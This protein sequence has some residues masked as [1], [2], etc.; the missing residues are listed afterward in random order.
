[1]PTP[2]SFTSTT[3]AAGRWKL[4]ITA[5]GGA[6]T[7]VT[8]F[9]AAPTK[10][11]S[12]SFTD[13]FG[14]SIAALTFP[15]ITGY[16]DLTA[17]EIGGWLSDES[18]VD[19]YWVPAVAGSTVINPVTGQKDL[20]L[21]TPAVVWEGFIASYDIEEDENGSHLSVQ[22]QGALMQLDRYKAKP[23]Y[24][25]RPQTYESMIR[26]EFDRAYR[27]NLRTKSMP[28]PE[29]PTG[30]TKTM[31]AG[32]VNVYTP[33][34]ASVGEKITGYS[35]RDTGS[36]DA[37]LTGFIASL[38][39]VM[40]TQ[41]DSGVLPGNQW[42]VLKDPGR[43]PALRVRDRFRTP[44]FSVWYGQVGVRCGRMTRD[45]TQRVNVI[46]GEGT[47]L[48]GTAWRNAVISADGSTTD[49]AP[50]AWM[51]EVY[52]PVDNPDYN[53]NKMVLEAYTRY[54]SGFDQVS[55]TESNK[56]ILG[57]DADPGWVG[58][59]RLSIDPDTMSRFQ[60]QA[61]MTVLLKG[62]AGT[63]STGMP[64]HIAEVTVSPEDG[65]VLCKLDSKYRDLLTLEEVVARTRDPLTPT[66]MLQINRRTVLIEDIV[67]PWDYHAGSGYMPKAGRT[68]LAHADRSSVFPWKSTT[69]AFPPR[70]HPE[71]YI[72]V[73]GKDGSKNN[74][75]TF[76]PVLMSQRG[77]IR[78]IEMQAY[79]ADGNPLKAAFHLSLYYTNV[80]VTAM[81]M[82]NGVH[83]PFFTGAFESTQP[84]G[85]PWPTGNFFAPD[86]S[87]IIGWGNSDQP[88]GYSPGSRSGGNPITGQL[89]DE[90]SWS[91]DCMNNPNFDKNARPGQ[92]IPT[93]AITVYGALY[94]D[95]PANVYFLGRLYRQ[96]PGT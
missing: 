28:K 27:P 92:K 59:L 80:T 19:I 87:I 39:A 79:D 88:A 91:F 41:D 48:D 31:P 86:E 94:T 35:G 65:T 13:P 57:R 34:G 53:P 22:C 32:A 64:F 85:L 9:R 58:E 68:L 84:N 26:R 23:S 1:M 44:D 16:D 51:D 33:Q 5:P 36:W 67:A 95:Y 49:Y 62:F 30:W 21:G 63:G 12:Y 73:K 54:N 20:G 6:A 25:A 42:T 24:P 56:Q 40:F 82:S 29:W 55:A 15:Q 43:Q 17:P 11:E 81:P 70:H 61:G 78:R 52:P 14:D 89:V 46:Y 90:A 75:W 10:I 83:S 66:K 50:L 77:S 69:N 37:S 76:F 38:L 96:E 93:S 45:S 47:S 3:T 18:N 4:V 72:K 2:W 71:Y 8:N 60:V 74:R 7:D